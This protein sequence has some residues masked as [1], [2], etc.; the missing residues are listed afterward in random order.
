[1]KRILLSTPTTPYPLQPWHDTPTDIMRQRFFKGQGIFTFEAHMHLVAP[2]IIAQNISAPATVLDHPTVDNWMEEIKKGYDIVGIS[3]LTPSFEGVMEM[4]RM[5]RT[6]SPKSE[7]V[8]GGFLA[9]SVGAYYP[10]EEWKKLA[11][12]LVLGDGIRW[13]REKLGDDVS[14]PVRQHFLP[15]C[16]MGTPWW[17]DKWPPGDTTAMIA[18]LGCNRG[19]DF[20][21]TTT[22]FGGQRHTMVSPQQLK[23]EIKMW[24]KRVPGTNII[25]YEEDQN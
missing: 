3:A 24:Q 14:A 18:A 15:R 7:I 8:L 17:V 5:V 13:F 19:C 16:A 6:H 20:C 22:H 2:F 11:D 1:V 9:Q 23:D 21:T 10:Q 12:H 4:C 25:I